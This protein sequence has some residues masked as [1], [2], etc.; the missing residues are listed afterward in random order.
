MATNVNECKLHFDHAFIL[1][2]FG[3]LFITYRKHEH[4]GFTYYCDMYQLYAAHFSFYENLLRLDEKCLQ[5][6]SSL[7]TD[8]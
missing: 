2:L 7:Y 6:V 3:L 5:T 1:Q 4:K 8:Y